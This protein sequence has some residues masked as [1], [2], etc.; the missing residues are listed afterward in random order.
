MANDIKIKVSDSDEIEELDSFSSSTGNL[1]GTVSN[2]AKQLVNLGLGVGTIPLK[3][4]PAASRYH[5]K[6]AVHECFLAVRSVVDGFN[7]TIDNTLVKS[8]EKDKA[9]ANID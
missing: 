3:L 6:N 7:E 4:L 2:F 8:M 5:T 1:I 9:R